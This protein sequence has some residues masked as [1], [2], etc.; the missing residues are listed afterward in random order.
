MSDP[1]KLVKLILQGNAGLQAL[2]VQAGDDS[3]P[4]FGGNLPE[5]YNPTS[6][7]DGEHG[8]GPAVTISIKGGT[9]NSEIPLQTVSIQVTGWTGVNE[10]VQAQAVY[11]AIFQALHGQ[12]NLDFGDDGK[13]LSCIEETVA[14]SMVDPDAGW[15]MRVGSFTLM[16]TGGVSL[17]AVI[18]ANETVKQ[19]VDDSIA[20]ALASVATLPIA[21]SDVT[22]LTVDLDTLAAA[23]AAETGRAESVEGGIEGDLASEVARA[24]AAEASITARL[25]L[26]EINGV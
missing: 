12:Q 6:M 24:Q 11:E 17:T 2:L 19:Y 3:W 22:G 5:H 9:T 25:S 14:S 21:E 26:D 16:V 13:L 8:T 15:V 18:T 7:T 10:F 23:I 20:T 1:V 4:I